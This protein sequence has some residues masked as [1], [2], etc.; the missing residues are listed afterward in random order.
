MPRAAF[1]STASRVN[2]F[3]SGGRTH[4]TRA[5]AASSERD[6][7]DGAAGYHLLELETALRE[8]LA[9]VIVIGN[10]AR[11]NA[12]H[13]IQLRAYGEARRRG[14]LDAR[15]GQGTFVSETTVR[16]PSPPRG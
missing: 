10:D 12:E 9:V 1:A 14:L 4:S 2:R 3:S 6:T 5:T 13:Q 16:S 7:G 8:N 15:V 11:W